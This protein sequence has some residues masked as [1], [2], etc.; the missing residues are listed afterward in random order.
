MFKHLW[1]S[2]GIVLGKRRWRR[3]GS[4]MS[5]GMRSWELRI[6]TGRLELGI[7]KSEQKGR[8]GMVI[9]IS[10]GVLGGNGLYTSTRKEESSVCVEVHELVWFLSQSVARSCQGTYSS[11]G[12]DTVWH[13]MENVEV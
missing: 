3:D 5:R 9:C 8:Y 2:E 7:R 11:M 1:R 13:K 6:G 12:H 10:S 4:D